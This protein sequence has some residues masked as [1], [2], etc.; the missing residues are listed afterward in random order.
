MVHLLSAIVAA[1]V[2]VLSL[3]GLFYCLQLLL[4]ILP[5]RGRELRPMVYGERGRLAVIIPA[6]DEGE[7][8]LPILSMLKGQLRPGDKLVVVAD[9]CSDDTA[10]QARSVGAIVV[11][12]RDEARRG[13]GYALDFGIRYLESDSPD[14]VVFFDA[15]SMIEADTLDVLV[16]HCYS[17]GRPIQGKH[18]MLSVEGARIDAP[19]ASFG[20]LVKN[21][22]RLLG[23]RKLGLPSH[24]TGSGIACPWVVI[25]DADLAHSHAAEDKKL[26]LDLTQAG[27]PPYYCREASIWAA[28]PF[29][30]EGTRTQRERWE[31]GHLSLVR[32]APQY[33]RAALR[34]RDLGLFMLALDIAVPPM[35][36][37][38]FL[39]A[40]AAIMAGGLAFLGGWVLPIWIASVTLVCVVALTLLAWWRYGREVLPARLLPFL[41]H[42]IWSKIAVYSRGPFR[43]S[44]S[45]WIRTDRSRTGN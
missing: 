10:A 32:I 35:F 41:V 16:S 6:H 37:L 8:I 19:V 45:Q 36:L 12:R 42:F 33:L 9:N 44:T 24:I 4:A 15:D 17:S 14:M 22:V 1:M 43:S 7:G 31:R 3:L 2:V 26:G 5:V 38:I 40:A 23:L 25:R 29:S 21:D 30:A 11:E 28:A 18:V 27:H 13:K 39:L 20:H 34:K